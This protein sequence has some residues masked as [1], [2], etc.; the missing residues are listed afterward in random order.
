MSPMSPS[1]YVSDPYMGGY[2][3]SP[4]EAMFSRAPPEIPGTR[5]TFIA[6]P[7]KVGGRLMGP[8]AGNLRG[9]LE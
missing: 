8:G 2:Y 7:F 6:H 9:D 4:P 1:Y 5:E 3:P